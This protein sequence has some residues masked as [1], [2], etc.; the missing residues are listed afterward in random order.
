MPM[1]KKAKL[2]ES[3]LTIPEIFIWESL[4]SYINS[5]NTFFHGA[6]G[7]GECSN[8]SYVIKKATNS[9]CQI[10]TPKPLSNLLSYRVLSKKQVC[11]LWYSSENRSLNDHNVKNATTVKTRSTFLPKHI[12][13]WVKWPVFRENKPN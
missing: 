3:Y 7:P 9:F 5:E 13:N 1:E 8:S 6:S 11:K 12:R 10:K 4:F 2:D